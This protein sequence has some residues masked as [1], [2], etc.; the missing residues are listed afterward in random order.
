MKLSFS[1]LGCPDWTM[2]QV[3]ARGVEYGFDGV[4]VRGFNGETDLR[5]LTSTAFDGSEE[6]L[7][8][9]DEVIASGGL[10]ERQL[11]SDPTQEDNRFL[12]ALVSLGAYVGEVMN[13]HLGTV[14]VPEFPEWESVVML[15]DVSFRPFDWVFEVFTGDP[16]GETTVQ[17]K[18]AEAKALLGL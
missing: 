7:A 2:A 16:D 1:T 10:D 12:E 11:L 17:A 13:R 14:W 4:E 15:D 18:Y 8:G 3:I 9:V 5:K 6:S